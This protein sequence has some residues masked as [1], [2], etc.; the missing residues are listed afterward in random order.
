MRVQTYSRKAV[1]VGSGR[2]PPPCPRIEP[3]GRLNS[4]VLPCECRGST[5]AVTVRGLPATVDRHPCTSALFLRRDL[6]GGE[7]YATEGPLRVRHSARPEPR[8]RSEQSR[9]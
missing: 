2:D 6:G 5:G 3:G 4:P 9:L 1:G 7:G 8:R